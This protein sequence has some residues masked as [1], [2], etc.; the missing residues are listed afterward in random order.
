MDTQAEYLLGLCAK[1]SSWFKA[2]HT[3]ALVQKVIQNRH[4][5]LS[6]QAVNVYHSVT[7]DDIQVMSNRIARATQASS[8]SDE[9]AY[10]RSGKT[11]PKS[12]SLW[13]FDCFLDSEGIIRVGGRIKH[14]TVSGVENHPIIMPKKSHISD[15]IV[16]HYHKT[17]GHQGRTTTMGAVRSAGYWIVG[18]H[19][20]VST[21]VYKC[22]TCRRLHT[23]T[24]NQ[25]MADLPADSV[26]VAA[27]FPNKWLQCFLAT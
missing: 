4:D 21:L 19:G 5:I 12:S 23:P 6:K 20:F 1:F 7:V 26:E 25:K 22:V 14:A 10:L 27:P 3:L 13:K 11:I 16:A 2:V 17:C 8:F 9:V 24:E 18:L 15:I